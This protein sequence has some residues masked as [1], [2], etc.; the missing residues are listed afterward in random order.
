M[1]KIIEKIKA[2][3]RVAD[4]SDERGDDQG[5]WVYAQGWCIESRPDGE[6]NESDCLHTIHED[7]PSECWKV[8]RGLKPCNCAGHCDRPA[9]ES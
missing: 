7:S 9:H 6:H 8:M 3:P 4:I 1:S 2:D 5:F